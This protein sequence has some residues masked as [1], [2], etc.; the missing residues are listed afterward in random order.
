MIIK[1]VKNNTLD[2]S[3]KRG[4]WKSTKQKEERIKKNLNVVGSYK[5]P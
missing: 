5:N 1:D 3:D 4:G 2:S